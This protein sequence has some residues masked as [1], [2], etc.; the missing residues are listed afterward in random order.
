MENALGAFVREETSEGEAGVIIDSDVETFDAGA[1]VAEGTITGGAHAWAKKAAELLD[2]EVEE[3]AGGGAFVAPRRRFRRIERGEPIEVM[4]AQDAGKSGLG[5]REHHHDLSVGAALAAQGEDLGFK[6]RS[7]LAR[8]MMRHRRTI[9]QARGK[10][11]LFGAS[12]PAADGL[13][14][15][16]ESNGSGAQGE[17]ELRVLEGHLSP[18]ERSKRGISVHVVRTQRR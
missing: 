10:A 9:G 3:F 18:G 14:A 2:V 7:G 4:T 17:A 16:T 12:E 15:N 11:A 5:D 13:F 6:L 8:L 1:W